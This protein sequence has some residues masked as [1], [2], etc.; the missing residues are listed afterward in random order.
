MRLWDLKSQTEATAFLGHT[1]VVS[2]L[3]VS[4]DDR[5]V[6]SGSYDKTVRCWD[7]EVRTGISVYYAI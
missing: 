3:G 4:E 6:Y 7:V 2:C 1:Q 5:C